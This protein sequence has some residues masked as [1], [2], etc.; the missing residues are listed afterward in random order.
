MSG[1]QQENKIEVVLNSIKS[2]FKKRRKIWI[3]LVIIGVIAIF[4]SA[5]VKSIFE[6]LLPPT[7][8]A[9][10]V[11]NSKDGWIPQ[12][13]S[14]QNWGG[15]NT[16]VSNMTKK[17]HHISQGTRTLPIPY[18]WFLHL[19]KADATPG[20]FIFK[21]LFFMQSEDFSGNDHLLRFGFIRSPKDPAYNPDGLPIGFASSPSINL[22]GYA[23]RTEGIGFTCA[24]CHTG[25][26]IYGEGD[27]TVEYVVEGA[28]ASTDLGLLTAS[29]SAALGQTLLS[30]KIPFFDGRF[31]RFAKNILGINYSASGKLALASDLENIV[32]AAATTADVIK[33]REGF[34][35]LD[36]LNRIGNQVF[37]KNVD[38]RQN[39]QPI[40]A[41]VNYPHIWTTS[42]FKWVQYDGSIMSPLVRNAGEAMG[43]NAHVSMNS[44]DNEN[45]FD[46]SIPYPNLV[47]L[48]HFL[49]GDELNTG[50]TA[51][52]WTLDKIDDNKA[53]RGKALYQERCQGCH[54]PTLDNPLIYNEKYFSKIAYKAV[55]NKGDSH[56]TSETR[57]TKDKYLDVKI[58]P[59]SQVGTDPGQAE[60]LVTRTINTAGNVKG[61]IV[62]RTKGLGVDHY[63]CGQD[64]DQIYKGEKP[65]LI[66]NVKVKDG[67]AISFGY[68]LGALVEQTNQAWFK[69]TGITDETLITEL[70]G[71]R[72]NC[73]QAGLG[74]K[75]RPLNGVWATAPF[76]HNSSVA[77][78]KDLLCK[79]IGERPRFLQ[80][81]K[82]DF[83]IN[84]I[85]IK[86][87]VDFQDKAES[88]VTRDKLYTSEG[89]FILDAS[90][91]GNSNS[92][93]YFSKKYDKNKHYSEQEKG[94]IGEKFSPQQ[95]DDIIE[96]LKTI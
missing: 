59:I 47:W 67:G 58:I 49:A 23:T 66:D 42:W 11:G 84:N 44:P 88:Y 22:P 4:T 24:A 8:P 70:E 51:P 61:P 87:P 82:I 33:V 53:E 80:L 91:P 45:R 9:L 35:R 18:D 95:C 5:Q 10:Q 72:P 74:Y 62:D 64:A 43:V 55:H 52:Q 19:E 57:Y 37:S 56:S 54:L 76:L 81:G 65:D 2:F 7:L 1:E 93:H 32:K 90:T 3:P 30:S 25:H 41:P 34:T 31:D 27:N 86:Q 94:V 68:A 46:S 71:G 79:D 60:V 6:L 78:L 12:Y 83:D 77:T 38:I 63:I 96:Y 75:A 89:Y 85:G 39:Y 40:D 69:Q 15:T 17:Y 20:S 50:L 14:N 21:N 26:F 13:W 48:E 92:G 73:I 28:P 36:A 29:L 16:Q